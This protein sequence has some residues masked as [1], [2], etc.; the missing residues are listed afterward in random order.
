MPPSFSVNRD[1]LNIRVEL[2]L[3]SDDHPLSSRPRRSLVQL[4]AGPG[5]KH[6]LHKPRRL[7][8]GQCEPDTLTVRTDVQ[9][10]R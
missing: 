10:T 1:L 7:L 2:G 8:G 5:P 9:G 4:A 6:D 3:V